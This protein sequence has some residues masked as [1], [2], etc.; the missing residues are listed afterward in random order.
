MENYGYKEL[1]QYYDLFYSK[2]NYD[3]ETIFI[4]RILKENNCNTILDVG[5]GTGNHILRLEKLGYECTGIDLN[6]EMLDIAKNKVK[7]PLYNSN[8]VDFNLNLQ[9]DG[10]ICMFAAFNHIIQIEEARV[11][12][13]NFYNHLNN[14]GV[15]LIDLHQPIKSGEKEDDFGQIKRIMKWDYNKEE[16]I[17]RTQVKFIK[18]NEVI[19]DEHT[20]RIYNVDLIKKIS[21]TVGFKYFSAYEGYNFEQVKDTSKNIEIVLRK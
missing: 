13:E 21:E 12:L 1:A 4:D 14:N 15:I 2:K 10:I 9:F 8:M 3:E 19:E 18:S 5:C 6:Y 7:A 16:G 20:M 11:T 17:E